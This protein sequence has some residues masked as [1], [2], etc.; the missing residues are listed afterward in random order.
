[1]PEDAK[2]FYTNLMSDIRTDGGQWCR[3]TEPKKNDQKHRALRYAMSDEKAR[4]R[5][6]NEPKGTA[7]DE[8]ADRR[9]RLRRNTIAKMTLIRSQFHSLFRQKMKLRR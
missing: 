2:R 6:W 3:Y 4:C 9:K 5:G 7:P 8:P 1:M